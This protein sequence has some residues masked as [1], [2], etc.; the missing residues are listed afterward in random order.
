[1]KQRPDGKS[2][3]FRFL[4]LIFNLFGKAEEIPNLDHLA[5]IEPHSSRE[6][7]E[8]LVLI[9]SNEKKIGLGFTVYDGYEIHLESA[10]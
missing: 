2:Q 9:A 3:I 4:P 10:V 6:P 5:V 8:D 7:A 1:M